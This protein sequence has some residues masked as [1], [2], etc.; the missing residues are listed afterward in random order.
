MGL[1]GHTQTL[2]L[3]CG[4]MLCAIAVQSGTVHAQQAS[5]RQDVT[6]I[7]ILLEPDAT[8]LKHQQTS[9]H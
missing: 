9:S 4:A 1:L 6:A 7:D 3:L 8:M 2:M 5:A